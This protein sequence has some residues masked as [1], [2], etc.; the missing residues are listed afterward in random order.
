M[1]TKYLLL[2]FFFC[3]TNWA[4]G[5][6]VSGLYFSYIPGTNDEVELINGGETY[7]GDI[8]IPSLVHFYGLYKV[9]RISSSAFMNSSHMT[10]VS[11]PSS[12]TAIGDYAFYGCSGL[13]VLSIPGSVN[14]IG[15]YAFGE[16][17]NLKVLE[18]PWENPLEIASSTVYGITSSCKLVVPENSLAEYSTV[19]VWQDFYKIDSSYLLCDIT[20][21]EGY[22]YT[23]MSRIYSNALWTASSD[24]NWVTLNTSAGNGSVFF[25]ASLSENE[26]TETR[27][28]TIT[29][30]SE[31]KDTCVIDITQY[32]QNFSKWEYV[33]SI[34]NSGWGYPTDQMNKV[35]AQGDNTVYLIG[36][37]GYIAKSSDNALTWNKQYFPTK[38]TFNDIAFCNDNIGFIVGN[39]G[40]ILRTEDA[41]AN[42]TQLNSGTTQNINAIAAT[43][44]NYIWA[45]G[46][47]GLILESTDIGETWAI[48]DYTDNRNLYDIKFK[49][50]VGYIVG[51]RN[52]VICIKEGAP[53]YWLR[54]AYDNPDE[55]DK[56]TS[57]SITNDR[58]Y[59]LVERYASY[60]GDMIVYTSDNENWSIFNLSS[61][62]SYFPITND[63]TQIFFQNDYTAYVAYFPPLPTGSASGGN[64]FALAKTV[65]GGKTWYDQSFPGPY[66][67]M[68]DKVDFSFS[69]NGEYGYLASGNVLL[70]TP[71]T[72][73]FYVGLPNIKSENSDLI[74]KQQGHELQIS[75][76][77]KTITNIEI[78]SATGVK[79]LQ[80]KKQ[81]Q[82]LSIAVNNLQKGVYVINVLFSDRT[83]SIAKWIKK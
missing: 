32:P 71:Y 2:A 69:E 7:S 12:I 15:E 9:T 83:N 51:D 34:E 63:L 33:R 18:V 36:E 64:R 80:E 60:D 8:D 25:I 61:E 48:K 22:A 53:Y 45:V 37:N 81:A 11:I 65:D 31:K 44:E 27:F 62:D 24:K 14:S 21:F 10:S 67:Q 72:G 41:G 4:Y 35:Y 3:M 57:L 23:L 40:T 38:E 74:L 50:D 55:Y 56:I 46:N 54:K 28:A 20:H 75:S 58:V 39:N 19:P 59:A 29:I 77:T 73:D 43:S 66:W 47:N 17:V 1:K 26:G 78:F 76:P 79:L 42:W 5:F 6:W 13:T 52:Q 30:I 82:E 49:G 68:S 70:R 16:C